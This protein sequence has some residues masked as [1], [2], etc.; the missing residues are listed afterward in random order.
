LPEGGQAAAQTVADSAFKYMTRPLY[1]AGSQ[2]KSKIKRKVYS[3]YGTRH[4]ARTFDENFQG[5]GKEQQTC[6]E[7]SK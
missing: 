7:S 2:N 6:A 3:A 4:V 5:K 1:E